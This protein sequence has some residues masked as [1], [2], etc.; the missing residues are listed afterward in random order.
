LASLR[1]GAGQI[2]VLGQNVTNYPHSRLNRVRDEISGLLSEIPLKKRSHAELA[3]RLGLNSSDHISVLFREDR[4]TPTLDRLL[5]KLGKLEQLPEP[6]PVTPCLECGKPHTIGWCIE[7]FG[8]PKRPGRKRATR[9][10]RP[11][12]SVAAD[13]PEMAMKQLEKYYPGQ[14]FLNVRE[15]YD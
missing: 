4:V 3:R 7:E 13:D 15:N 10:R 2:H 9:N 1:P 6:V 12:F 5:V 8:E 14:F 11:R